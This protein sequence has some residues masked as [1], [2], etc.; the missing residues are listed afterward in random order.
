M[1]LCFKNKLNFIFKFFSKRQILKN[2]SLIKIIKIQIFKNNF[3]LGFFARF[4]SN[5]IFF[6]INKFKFLIISKKK[7]ILNN[8]TLFISS[9]LCSNNACNT[10]EY[11]YI[12]IIILRI[13]LHLT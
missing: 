8:K 7:Y 6:I 5:F 11:L 12:Y 9:I 3:M 2:A 4:S 10:Y 1:R 13:I